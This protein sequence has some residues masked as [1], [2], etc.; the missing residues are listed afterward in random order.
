MQR[1]ILDEFA[2]KSVVINGEGQITCASG[3]MEKFLGIGEGLFQNNVIKLARSGLRVGIRT[4]LSEAIESRRT[5]KNDN[6]AIKTEKGVNRVRLTVQP[7]PQLGEGSGLYLLVF[8]DLGPLVDRE[9]T[10]VGR[11]D[12]EANALIEHLEHEL[13]TTRDDLERTIQDIEAANQELKSSN[14]ELLSMNEELQ[15]ANEELETSRE[16][17]QSGNDALVRANTDLENLLA[18]TQVATIFLDEQLNIQR[19]TPAVTDIYNL[20]PGDIGRPLFH[21]THRA[22]TMPPLPV[23]DA[24]LANSVEQEIE[25]EDG[26]W[27]IRRVL[28]YRN[29]EGRP[30]G[31]VL[32]FVDVTDLKCAEAS[33]RDRESRLALALDAGGM[34]TWQWDLQTDAVRWGD[35]MASLFEREPGEIPLTAQAFFDRVHPDDLSPLRETLHQAIEGDGNYNAEFRIILPDRSIRWLAGRGRVVR[36]ASGRPLR[37]HGVNFDI[38]KR[39]R[40]EESLRQSESQFRA[41]AESIPQLAWM[42]EPD[43]HIFWYNKRWFEYTGTTLESVQGW[44]WQ[45]VLDPDVLPAVMERW[46]ASIEHGTAFEMVYPLRSSDGRFRAFLTRVLPVKDEH[47][48]V[49]RWFG[50]STDIEAQKQAED[51][52]KRANRHKDEFL[53]MLAHELRNPLSPIRNAVHLLKFASPNDPTLVGARDDRPPGDPPRAAGRRPPGCQPDHPGQDRSPARTRGPGRHRRIGRRK[54]TA[55]HRLASAPPGSFPAS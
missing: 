24:Q 30:Q 46:R 1:I 33:L 52:L 31:L 17:I 14:E 25:T 29:S 28:P 50:T 37:M 6:L 32:T 10:G 3:G 43:G 12:D 39:K 15:S 7:M 26:K 22:I 47:G 35:R 49:V 54:R 19:F 5:V 2:P 44:G 21:I 11:S 18:S 16:E 20:I 34:G 36:D 53:A 48:A 45:S 38:T 23:G 51:D 8:E 55:P 42:A 13:Q 9:E 40:V 41:L 4:A 27:Y